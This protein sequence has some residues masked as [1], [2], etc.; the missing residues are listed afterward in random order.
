M[1]FGGE[2]NNLSTNEE[3]ATNP[4]PENNSRRNFLRNLGALI[5]G[6][7]IVNSPLSALAYESNEKPPVTARPVWDNDWNEISKQYNLKLG[8]SFSSTVNGITSNKKASILPYFDEN[9]AN[10]KVSTLDSN[11]RFE[12][13]R[14]VYRRIAI[15]HTDVDTTSANAYDQAKAVRNLEINGSQQFNDIGY[16]FLIASDGTIIEG[17][18]SG[19][20]GSNA[21]QTKEANEKG[22]GLLDQ[23]YNASGQEYYNKL[24]KYIEAMKM[25]PDYGTLGIALCG[26]FDQGRQPS[27]QQQISLIKLLNWTKV[28]YDI[29]TNN[30][31]YHRE[32]KSRVIE[33]S[34]LTFV[35]T[36]GAQD[37]VCPGR[38]FP[39]ISNFTNSL[40][41]DSYNAK[42]K[43]I[44]LDRF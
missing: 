43:T 32:V 25:D 27:P 18:P 1:K 8:E 28:E 7:A 20:V 37:T 41:A 44:L 26:D 10:G 22:K 17:R 39:N 6:T 34:G 11:H 2:K 40:K 29:P 15:H 3:K 36:N 4:K 33:A 21:G 23:I 9:F 38:S 5:A 19:R 42:Q 35:G 30:I 14:N 31:I 24:Q 13:L 12:N 16:H